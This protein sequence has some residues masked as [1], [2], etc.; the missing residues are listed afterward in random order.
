MYIYISNVS[1][2]IYVAYKPNYDGGCTTPIL[3]RFRVSSRINRQVIRPNP[4]QNPPIGKRYLWSFCWVKLWPL[5]T[6]ELHI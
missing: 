3:T 4:L 6:G 5:E 2:S 1:I